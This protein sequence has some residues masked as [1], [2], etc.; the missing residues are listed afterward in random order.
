MA[1]GSKCGITDYRTTDKEKILN[2]RFTQINADDEFFTAKRW[3]GWEWTT[4]SLTGG[5]A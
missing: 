1:V 5:G 3:C 4:G 2:R